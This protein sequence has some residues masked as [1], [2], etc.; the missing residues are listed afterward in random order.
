MTMQHPSQENL[1]AWLAGSL[2]GDDAVEIESHLSACK[3]CDDTIAKLENEQATILEIVHEAGQSVDGEANRDFDTQRPR[4]GQYQITEKLGEGGMGAVYKAVHTKLEKT[5]ALKL[6]PPGRMKDQSV[7]DRFEREMKAVGRLDHPNIVRAMDAGVIDDTHFLVMEIVDGHDLNVILKHHGPLPVADACEIIRQAAV[8]LDEA[9]HC[10]MVHRDIKPSN[11]MLARVRVGQPVVKILDMGLA[12]LSSVGDDGE[13]TATGQVMGTVDYMSPEQ[14]DNSHTVD[15]R[16]DIYSLGATLFKLLSGRA[17]FD[18]EQTASLIKKLTAIATKPPPLLSSLR[19]DVPNEL[20]ELTTRMIAKQPEER[21]PTPE[22]LVGMMEPFS[23]GHNLNA[24]LDSIP[25]SPSEA[26][27]PTQSIRSFDVTTDFSASLPTPAKPETTLLPHVSTQPKTA[28]VRKSPRHKVL[29]GLGMFATL[30]AVAGITFFLKTDDGSTVRFEIDDPDIQLAFDDHAVTIDDSGK[31]YELTPGSRKLHVRVGD[32][33]FETTDFKLAKGEHVRMRVTYEDDQLALTKNGQIQALRLMREIERKQAR[34]E[35]GKPGG[36]SAGAVA[37]WVIA[38]GGAFLTD[39]QR[40]YTRHSGAGPFA[41]TRV[42][43]LP[44]DLSQIKYVKMQIAT[45]Q[46]ADR[47]GDLTALR[48]LAALDFDGTDEV[49]AL[50]WSMLKDLRSVKW[51]RFAGTGISAE[52]LKPLAQTFSLRSLELSGRVSGKHLTHLSD[53]PDLERLILAGAG[54]DGVSLSNL[55]DLQNLK[56][57]DLTEAKLVDDAGMV[58]VGKLSKLDELS[59]HGT[60]V[61]DDGLRHLE[62]LPNLELI[63]TNHSKVTSVG[64]ARL[65]RALPQ[66]TIR[67]G[68]SVQASSFFTLPASTEMPDD[69]DA[70][71]DKPTSAT[72]QALHREAVEL[73]LNRK[74]KAVVLVDGQRVKVTKPSEIPD[75]AF[76]LRG[77]LHLHSGDSD[78]GS[79]NDADCKVLAR[80][81]TVDELDVSGAKVTAAGLREFAKTN[82]VVKLTIPRKLKGNAAVVPLFPKVRCVHV[83]LH[84]TNEFIAALRGNT[85]IVVVSCYRAI[86]SEQSLAILA[87]LPNLKSLTLRAHDFITAAP[88]FEAPGAFPVLE[89]LSIDGITGDHSIPPSSLSPLKRLKKLKT[90]SVGIPGERPELDLY[91]T[92]EFP[93]CIRVPI[94]AWGILDAMMNRLINFAPEPLAYENSVTRYRLPT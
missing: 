59:I 65:K 46:M 62:S 11:L 40:L 4:L 12:L 90:I 81:G 66:C 78:P 54:V 33:E 20:V 84:E 16:S 38:N 50:D 63:R 42:E 55:Q 87:E 26:L 8:G 67:I 43:N 92:T 76:E 52:N 83:P 73:V 10:G 27:E 51:V 74:A 56:N 18:D 7:V 22:S 64:L 14:C 60:S 53:F 37:E 35:I 9:D 13:L 25:S 32:L 69:P 2:D 45:K 24:L 41:I 31:E 23:V 79:I 61:T 6:L 17:P 88:T 36:P 39:D 75:K 49:S 94:T 86:V 71:I 21:P 58:Y 72:T 1:L 91:I 68:D 85:S 57:L 15:I 82:R 48:N 19:E 34:Q 93:E 70:D 80:L 5:V 77:V 29:I 44:S 3:N 28:G 47:L 30:L 89:H